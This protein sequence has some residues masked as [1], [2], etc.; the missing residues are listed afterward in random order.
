MFQFHAVI[1]DLNDELGV[2]CFKE[3]R[4]FVSQ[5]N[6]IYL[7]ENFPRIIINTIL[8]VQDAICIRQLCYL[9]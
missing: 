2:V 6:M 5:I 4:I 9:D 7:Q 1:N 8:S 3:F